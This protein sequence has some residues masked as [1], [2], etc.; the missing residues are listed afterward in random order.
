MKFF[1]LLIFIINFSYQTDLELVDVS[2]P[3]ENQDNSY[4]FFYLTLCSNYGEIEIKD[5]SSFNFYSPSKCMILAEAV[6]SETKEFRTEGNYIKIKYKIY[7]NKIEIP[8]SFNTINDTY[9][10]YNRCFGDTYKLNG[11]K[12]RK[13]QDKPIIIHKDEYYSNFPNITLILRVLF[14]KNTSLNF[15]TSNVTIGNIEYDCFFEQMNSDNSSTQEIECIPQDE[16]KTSEYIGYVK[17]NSE[18]NNKF[19]IIYC[20]SGA[21]EPCE[22]NS[23]Y[24]NFDTPSNNNNIYFAE[25]RK[26][27]FYFSLPY[28]YFTSFK[29]EQIYA[30]NTDITNY[31]TSSGLS[32]NDNIIITCYLDLPSI[33]NKKDYELINSSIIIKYGSESKIFYIKRGTEDPLN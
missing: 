31:C 16:N 4:F 8:Y 3:N 32:Y 1:I 30:N 18:F 21:Y 9:T 33:L 12:K 27:V 14:D 15:T 19:N 17:Y 25:D 29:S 11:K 13:N 23:Y 6:S 10:I 2:I 22:I 28:L 26:T 24:I 5:I 20:H 7:S